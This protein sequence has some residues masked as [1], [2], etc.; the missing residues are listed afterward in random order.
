MGRPREQLRDEPQ[1]ADWR[2]WLDGD[3]YSVRVQQKVLVR[4]E[5]RS[6]A[7]KVIRQSES[8]EWDDVEG[9]IFGFYGYDYTVEEAIAMLAGVAERE[10]S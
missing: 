4:T 2:A 10:E 5:V 1:T 6:M 9:P 3:V 8:V 7:N